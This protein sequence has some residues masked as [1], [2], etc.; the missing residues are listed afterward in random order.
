MFPL[1]ETAAA[2]AAVMLVT[3]L[4]VSAVVQVIQ[5]L[6]ELRPRILGGM[7]VTLARNYRESPDDEPPT[8]TEQKAFSEAILSHPLLHTPEALDA[9]G[10]DRAKLARRLDYIDD[11]DLVALVK[12]PGVE[13]APDVHAVVKDVIKFE[14]FVAQWFDTVGA[15]ASQAFKHHM[16]RITLAVSCAVVVAFNLDGLHLVGD[17]YRDQVARGVLVKQVEAIRQTA[18]RLGEVE[19]RA[20]GVDPSARR[21]HTLG[22]LLVELKK[23]ETILD[24]A[25]LGVGWQSSWIVK[26]WRAYEGPDT[27]AAERPTRAGM[28]GDGLLWLSGLLFSCVMLSLGAPFWATMLGQLVNL[29]NAV[30]KA[31]SAPSGKEAEAEERKTGEAPKKPG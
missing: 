14:A 12:A 6:L 5:G 3:S 27:P 13:R 7:L 29:G 9:A 16:R 19:D 1:I 31:K 22:E 18:S 26:R 10:R 8:R 11:D 30:Q 2:F 20:A 17:L 15:T 21:D 4:F 23:T 28:I 25:S 24:E